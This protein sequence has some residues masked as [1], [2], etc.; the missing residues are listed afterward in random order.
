MVT[1]TTT[2]GSTC[3][4]TWQHDGT[5]KPRP[6]PEGFLETV[7][8]MTPVMTLPRAL[9]VIP[10]WNPFGFACAGARMAKA[11]DTEKKT[12]SRGVTAFCRKT[13]LNMPE[14][15]LALRICGSSP[16]PFMVDS[17]PEPLSA[18]WPRM[19]ELQEIPGTSGADLTGVFMARA[20]M[21]NAL[22]AKATL[23]A[24]TE[25]GF[26]DPAV[27]SI[28]TLTGACFHGADMT[29]AELNRAN[30]DGAD[31]SEAT[32]RQAKIRKSSLRG[33]DLRNA[34]LTK[35]NLQETD[36][37]GAD[38]T[39]AD[40]TGAEL[41]GAVLDKALYASEQLSEEQTQ[42]LARRPN[43]ARNPRTALQPA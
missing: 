29:K 26:T 1:T 41:K 11:L 30:A 37:T 16:S 22:L 38:L 28:S 7:A 18:V 10:F 15:I 27:L 5:A 3:P 9:Q 42:S 24:R 19:L 6:L 36:L 35:A 14:L 8:A 23:T 32:L 31:L 39:G 2:G 33:A 34:N 21:E 17:W 43:D 4:H 40:L 12:W 20:N 25:P 13:G